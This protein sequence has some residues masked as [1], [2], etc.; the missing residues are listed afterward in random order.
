MKDSTLMKPFM[1]LFI[2]LTIYNPVFSKTNST[3]SN[4]QF[5]QYK[6]LDGLSSNF[7]FDIEKDQSGRIWVA[8]QN[9]LTVIGGQNFIKYSANDSLP[10]CDIID[11]TFFDNEAYI[12]TSTD[13]IFIFNGEYFERVKLIQGKKISYMDKVGNSLF[14]S[15]DIDNLLYDGSKVEY[16]GWGFPKG[17]VVDESSYDGERWYAGKRNIIQEE[18][19]NKFKNYELDFAD[20]NIVIRCILY[21][22][23]MIYIGTNKGLYSWA[24]NKNLTLEERSLNVV[25]LEYFNNEIILVGTKKGIYSFQDGHLSP[26]KSDDSFN[27]LL[28]NVHIKN[29]K[30]IN[31]HEVWY[32]TFGQGILYHDPTSFYNIGK[33]DGLDVGGMVYDSES[34]NGSVYMGTNNGLFIVNSD[35]SFTHLD[36][37]DG[38][39]SNKIMDLE[40]NNDGVIY[41]ATTKGLSIYTNGS[42]TNYSKKN[43]LPSNLLLSLFIDKKDKEKIWL[44]SKSAGVALFD[45]ENFITYSKKD[46]LPTNWIQDIKQKK[47]GTIIFACYGYGISIFNGETFRN[48]DQGLVDNR[49]VT[50]AIDNR[51]EIWA[52]TESAGLALFSNENFSVLNTADGLGHNETFSLLSDNDN[53][54]VGTFG[55]GVSYL[56]DN[57]WFTLDTK[58]GLIGNTVGSIA[59]LKDDSFFI[60]CDNGVTIFTPN[61]NKIKLEVERVETPQTDILAD[62]IV[63]GRPGERFSIYINPIYYSA[64]DSY[65]NY[66]TRINDGNVSRNWSELFSSPTIEYI[67]GYKEFMIEHEPLEVGKYVLEIQAV[68]NKLNTSNIVEV[69]FAIVRV[70]YLNPITAIPFWLAVLGFG[71]FSSTTFVNYR[72]QKIKTKELQDAEMER[73]NAELEEAREF[74][75]S[76]LPNEMPISDDY[77]IIGFQKTATEVGGDYF[78]FIDNGDGRIIAICGDATGHGLTS[79]NV[80]AITKTALSSIRLDDPVSILD[81]LNKTL[82]R[83]NIGLNRMCLN[84]ADISNGKI[85][86]SSAGMPPAYFYSSQDETLKEIMVGAL[87]LGSFSKSIHTSEEIAFKN[88]GDTLVLLSDG[89][90]EAENQGGE[91]IGYEKTEEEIKSLI[92]L[93]VEEIKNGLVK[94]CESWLGDIDLKDD[95]TL[96]IIKKK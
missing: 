59:R 65:F 87:P 34:Y 24:K 60:G 53:I 91:M 93:N 22:D 40:I 2:M 33:K 27:G 78:D 68:N 80:V 76:L 11:I 58:D 44:G 3:L 12:A 8:T 62:E 86:F 10:S 96:V 88:K 56:N 30:V 4:G 43:G 9:G 77:E 1:Y 74:Q 46:G 37:K 54:W 79:G 51:G 69:P 90:P 39:P 21:K 14:I 47:D 50:L 45:G 13:G 92:N 57:Q 94:L 20:K 26:V 83:M 71:I 49:V 82:L 17:E 63:N 19:N 72:K 15:T 64:G 36:E 81:T 61:E 89:L 6:Y 16:M 66:R 84:I 55:G 67:D 7:I 5:F 75:Q 85:T 25:S 18:S 38:L 29:I 41:M 31:K 35:Y 73:Q 52:G 32:S 48:Y 42:F 70:W 95:M 28:S 23:K